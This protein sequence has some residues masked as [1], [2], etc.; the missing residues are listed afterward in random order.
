MH[1]DDYQSP[2][3]RQMSEFYRQVE[4]RRICRETLQLF[5][6]DPDRVLTLWDDPRLITGI[7][8]ESMGEV[9]KDSSFSEINIWSSLDR[10]SFLNL[11]IPS[12]LNVQVRTSRFQQDHARF[13]M[14][15]SADRLV[16]LALS[17]RNTKIHRK[18]VAMHPSTMV[19]NANNY[20]D[21]VENYDVAC[22]DVSNS[23][24]PRI[25]GIPLV[26]IVGNPRQFLYLI[27][28]PA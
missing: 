27:M 25:Y 14:P 11:P 22:L 20:P 5:L 28:S 3:H 9:R 10:L 16:R 26:S 21:P 2:T 6:D 4:Q 18:I 7:S 8:H 1:M 23:G 15:A 24:R 19:K 12:S 17:L 13:E